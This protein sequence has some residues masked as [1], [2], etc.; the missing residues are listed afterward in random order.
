MK[1]AANRTAWAIGHQRRNGFQVRRVVW[2]ML[3]ARTERRDDEEIRLAHIFVEAKWKR[4]HP[5][6]LNRANG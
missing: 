5:K 2:G 6:P 4:R 1:N 3:M